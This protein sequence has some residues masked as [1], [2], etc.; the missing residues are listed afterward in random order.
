[1]TTQSTT[2]YILVPGAFCL[3]IIY[4]S[5]A[6]RLQTLGSAVELVNLP[7]VGR[8]DNL[9]KPPG[10]YDDAAHVRNLVRKHTSAGNNVVLAGNSYG[11]IVITQ[12]AEGLLNDTTSQNGNGK[13]IHLVYLASLLQSTGLTVS[14][15]VEGKQPMPTTLNVDWLDPLAAESAGMA[16]VDAADTA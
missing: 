6:S 13:L 8:K 11:G 1:M 12:A 15:S 3:P 14:E 10:M 2:T 4:E 7:T 9:P 5:L 16:L